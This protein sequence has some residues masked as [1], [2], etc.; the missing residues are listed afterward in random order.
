MT[1]FP[2]KS[3]VL[4]HLPKLENMT[5]TSNLLSSLFFFTLIPLFSRNSIADDTLKQGQSINDTQ[6]IVSAAEIFELGFFSQPQATNLKYLA[7]WY[8][9]VT[10][11]TVVWVANR[12]TPVLSSS[13]TLN[14]RRDGNLVLMNQTGAAFWSSNST[15]SIQN[16]IAQLLDTGNL[17]LRDSKSE[18]Y[19]WQSFDYPTDTLLPG[20]KIGWDSKTGLNRKLKS[21]TS[22]NDVS[23][24]EFSFSLNTNGLP[25]F[26]VHKGNRTMFRGWPWFDHDFGQSYGNGFN[27]DLV[28]DAST[29]ISFS[30]N[31]SAHSR[32]RI[33]MDSSGSIL[34]H[35]WNDEGEKWRKAYSFDGAGCNDYDLC[36]NFGLCNPAVTTSCGCLNGFEQISTKNLSNGCVRR[37]PKICEA[38][39][40][41][42]KISKVKWPDS[43]GDS[44]KMKLG[45]KDC[46]AECLKDCGCLA[47]GTVQIP[48]IGLACVNWFHKLVDIRYVPDVGSGD[49]IY[50]RV[51]A[52]ELESADEKRSVAVVVAVPIVSVIAF[53]GLI[54]CWFFMRRRV[55]GN[56]EVLIVPPIQEHELEIPIGVLEAATENF[57]VFNK[58][59]E[60]GFGSV[61]KGK[62]PNG[63]EIAVKKLAETS[64]QGLQEFK[65][66]VLFISQLQHRNL[67]KLLGFC[68]HN[69]QILLI[70]EYLPNKS[71]DCFI[72]DDQRRSSLT[73]PRRI[74]IIIGIGRGLLYLHRDS[75]LRIIHRDLK[76]ANILL[77]NE[78]KPKISDFGMARMFR[79]DQTE[80]KTRRVVG[81]YGYMSPEYVIDG[82]FSVKSDVFSF[83]VMVLEIVSG[84]KNKGFFHPEH[85]LNLLGHAWNL[86]KEGRSLELIDV[87]LEDQFDEH[88]ALRYI[89]IGL[90][91]VQRRP[92]DRPIMSA[93]VSMLEN[94]NLRLMVPERPGFYEERFIETGID[95]SLNDQLSSSSN[96]VTVTLLDG[97]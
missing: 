71:L 2:P 24:G 92:E 86:W 72:F 79:E 61:Y 28:F 16:P 90:L 55:R 91:C 13:A 97:R 34:R 36:G 63:Q 20:M 41:F 83:G 73:W 4:I 38:G 80:T 33:V 39:D 49:D 52:S 88:E 11:K 18:D 57:S 64:G 21:W 22:S 10:P 17:V 48:K 45:V 95:S 51:A 85:Q 74:D 43:T 58:I 60:G 40:G 89:N 6:S 14:F 30:Y 42:I 8:K 94:E 75:R 31:D 66:E 54:G 5:P 3:I 67:V 50:V 26:F 9:G 46:E 27:Y 7:I 82:Y 59:G 25:Q 70:Y 93:V 69:E 47:Y 23:S 56:H 1:N 12:D 19:V 32:T 87:I 53:L 37:D 29:E 81:T 76:A 44:V 68:I 35:E 77:D 15:K 96:N 84:K 78:M 65:N 62:L